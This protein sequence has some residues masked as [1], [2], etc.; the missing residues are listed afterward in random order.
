MLS[1]SNPYVAAFL[2]V[3]IS[4]GEP[5]ATMTSTKQN[6][7]FKQCKRNILAVGDNLTYLESLKNNGY[8][9]DFIYIDPPYNTGGVFS[10]SDKRTMN[11][12]YQFMYVR[13]SLARDIMLDESSIFISIDDS[14]MV[15][16]R[17]ICDKVFGSDNFIGV[18]ITRQAVRSNS[19]L[20]NTIH[21]YVIVYARNIKYTNPFRIKRIDIP[22]DRRIIESIERNVART[23]SSG[24]RDA[25][26]DVLTDMLKR[27]CRTPDMSWLRNYNIVDNVGRVVFAKDLSVPGD[28]APLDIDEINM[29]LPALKTRR[30]SSARKF[31]ELYNQGRIIYK[32]GRPYAAHYLNEAEDN[33]VSILNFYSRQGTNDLNKLGLRG[34][35]DTPK[36]VEL[37]KY[38]IRVALSDKKHASVLDFFAGSGTTGQA[39]WEINSEDGVDYTFF[40]VQLD[41]PVDKRSSIA[42][43]YKVKTIDEMTQIRLEICADK[44]GGGQKFEVVRGGVF[45]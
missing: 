11:D 16:I 26:N 4:R 37:I 12:Y 2:V 40:L 33:V 35:F 6:T 20:I 36:P 45:A 10:Y 1:L 23:F 30:W 31:I 43:K 19:R 18:F 41:E 9:F 5:V 8:R 14:E 42:K 3:A 29:H 13:L 7:I 34:I 32:N 22:N 25:A 24:G 28:P 38:L 17:D 15:T 27:I 21:E 39:V 44:M